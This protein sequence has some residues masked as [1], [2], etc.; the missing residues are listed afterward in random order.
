MGVY[1]GNT[2]TSEWVIFGSRIKGDVN[3]DGT[4]DVADISTIIDV[5]AAGEMAAPALA[6]AADVNNDGSVDVADISTVIDIM[7]ASARKTKELEK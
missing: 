4:V 2:L 7:A 1:V 3:N 6:S 5:M